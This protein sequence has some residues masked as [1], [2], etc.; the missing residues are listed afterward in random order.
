MKKT[1]KEIRKEFES[2]PESRWEQLAFLYRRM[3]GRA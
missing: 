2:A 1:L 3:T